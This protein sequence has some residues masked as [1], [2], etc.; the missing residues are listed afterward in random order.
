M[1]TAFRLVKTKFA[2][3]P[4]SA[5]GARLY[6]GR[7]NSPGYAVVYFAESISLAVLE[8]LVHVES[9]RLLEA[10]SVIRIDFEETD[11]QSIALDHLPETWGDAPVP[12]E[13][14]KLGDEWLESAESLLLRVPSVV[15][16]QEHVFLLNP[17]HTSR[18][19]LLVTAPVPF[20]FDSR[21]F[22]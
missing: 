9:A 21:L 5:E 17:H 12:V 6:G 18:A 22:N 4:L 8:I 19:R 15:V 14:Q 1:P 11:F 10:Y 16:P 20:R 7:W 2:A 13:T 3:D